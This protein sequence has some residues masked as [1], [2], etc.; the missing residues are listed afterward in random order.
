MTRTVTVRSCHEMRRVDDQTVCHQYDTDR[1]KLQTP[2]VPVSRNSRLR[3]SRHPTSKCM[4]SECTPERANLMFAAAAAAPPL[5]PVLHRY[6]RDAKGP[7]GTCDTYR[8][9]HTCP[10]PHGPGWSMDNKAPRYMC[11][12]TVVSRRWGSLGI[13]IE[14]VVP[15]AFRRAPHLPPSRGWCAHDPFGNH[16]GRSRAFPAARLLAAAIRGGGVKPSHL[17]T[18]RRRVGAVKVHR[19]PKAQPGPDGLAEPAR[20]KRANRRVI[21]EGSCARENVVVAQ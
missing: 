9:A 19:P 21:G 3:A 16:N 13:E 5:P 17:A 18:P 2:A 4:L 6:A 20:A 8:H 7:P 1:P 11:L 15:M 14:H 12:H 10:A